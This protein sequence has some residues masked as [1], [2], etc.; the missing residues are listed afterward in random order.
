M[1]RGIFCSIFSTRLPSSLPFFIFSPHLSHNS[2][3]S[4]HTTGKRSRVGNA[5]PPRHITLLSGACRVR[6]VRIRVVVLV[7]RAVRTKDV[8]QGPCALTTLRGG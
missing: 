2:E 8:R 5:K 3:R 4:A 6:I 1:Q 7:R